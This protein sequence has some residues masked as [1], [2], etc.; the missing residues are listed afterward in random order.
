MRTA[1]VGKHQ[2]DAMGGLP[3]KRSLAAITR[4]TSIPEAQH[5]EH[6]FYLILVIPLLNSVIILHTYIYN[7]LGRLQSDSPLLLLY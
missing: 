3:S 4:L 1:Y 2:A 6:N 7:Y 5:P